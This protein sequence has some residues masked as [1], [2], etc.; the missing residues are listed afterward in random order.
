MKKRRIENPSFPNPKRRKLDIL[1][2][3]QSAAQRRIQYEESN[4]NSKK[5]SLS[6]TAMREELN[7][8]KKRKALSSS[9]NSTAMYMG[10]DSSSWK[11]HNGRL[12][13]IELKN[14]ADAKSLLYLQNPETLSQSPARMGGRNSQPTPRKKRRKLYKSKT[15]NFVAKSLGA[16]VLQFPKVTEMQPLLNSMQTTLGEETAILTQDIQLSQKTELS[17]N[18]SHQKPPQQHLFAPIIT[19]SSTSSSETFPFSQESQNSQSDV[20]IQK[21][22]HNRP[23][24]KN[25]HNRP[26]FTSHKPESWCGEVLDSEEKKICENSAPFKRE[27]TSKLFRNFP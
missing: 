7:K 22:N 15:A 1:A 23:P 4:Q 12:R 18:P 26:P 14:V 11:R 21:N 13:R 16:G 8:I 6:R 25:N 5:E 20:F 3:P 10:L 9:S 17:Q 19:Q 2:V 27:T 24:Q